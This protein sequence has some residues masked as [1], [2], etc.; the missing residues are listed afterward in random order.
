MSAGR[1]R[2]NRDERTNERENERREEDRHE[3]RAV[4]NVAAQLKN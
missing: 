2:K 1:K 3:V 4:E